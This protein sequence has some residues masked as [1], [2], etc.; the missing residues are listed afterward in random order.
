MLGIELIWGKVLK[1]CR[2]RESLRATGNEKKITYTCRDAPR[3]WGNHAADLHGLPYGYALVFVSTPNLT[4][5]VFA[6]GIR[7]LPR[8]SYYSILD[9]MSLPHSFFPELKPD[10]E[11]MVVLPLPIE[12]PS[13]LLDAANMPS[14]V[15]MKHSVAGVIYAF[16][17][18]L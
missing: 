7:V 6:A 5:V 8:Y 13:A 16:F 11:V 12:T 4:A 15:I 9:Q 18:V 14:K 10:S 2:P 1:K 3:K 17:I